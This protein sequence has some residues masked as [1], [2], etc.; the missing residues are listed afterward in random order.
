[1][2]DEVLVYKPVTK[3]TKADSLK[4]TSTRPFKVEAVNENGFKVNINC[5]LH[6]YNRVNLKKDIC[7][8]FFFRYSHIKQN[9]C[10][11]VLG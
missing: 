9:L 8:I 7:V 2:N 1:M 6:S 10:I 4:P 11:A 5:K 3:R